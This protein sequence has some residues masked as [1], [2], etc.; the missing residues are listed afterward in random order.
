VAGTSTWGK[1]LV[2]TVYNLSYGA[3]IA[4]TTAKYYTPS[5]RLIQRDY[6]SYFDYYTNFGPVD[7]TDVEP[8]VDD[9]EFE[10]DLGRPVFGGGGITPDVIVDP[11]E[12][13]EG[14]QFLFVNNSFF[15]FAIDY[16]R[17][18]AAKIS[19]SSWRPPAEMVDEFKEW[20]LEEGLAKPEKLAEIF[21]DEEV[22]EYARRQI[23]SDIF[24]AA[25]GTEASHRILAEGDVQI[26]A[27]LDL[28]DEASELL[29][30][31]RQLLEKR[32]RQLAS[33]EGEERKSSEIRPE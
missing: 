29:E 6:S 7:T 23:H 26:Q 9:P 5:G 2:Q 13:P 14:V 33:R 18:H 8:E 11:P 15:D 32:S 12:P 1:G 3:G 16:H 21:A 22:R 20:L 19:D 30:K 31:R 10:T 27:A 24:T 17:R 4:L 25:F 28:F